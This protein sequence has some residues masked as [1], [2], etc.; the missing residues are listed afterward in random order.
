MKLIRRG[1]TLVELLVV[2]GVLAVLASGLIIALNPLDKINAANDTKVQSDI[3]QIAGALASYAAAK[4]GYYPTQALGTGA[5]V[6]NGDLTVVP[7]APTGYTPAT[8]SYTALPVGCTATSCDN[9]RLSMQLKSKKYTA[10]PYWVW[11]SSTAKAGAVATA[12]I[13]P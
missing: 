7:L 12:L 9:A 8:Y 4:N 3:S 6:T 11:C 10:T 5:L 2:M 13:C 1:F